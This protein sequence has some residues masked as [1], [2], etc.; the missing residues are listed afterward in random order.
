MTETSPETV[1]L[2]K[3][4][5]APAAEGGGQS[6]RRSLHPQGLLGGIAMFKHASHMWICGAM[7]AAA[8]GVVLVTGKAAALLP[9]AACVVMMGAMML[10]MGGHGGGSG[11]DG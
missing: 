2:S 5:S 1:H 6:S 10:M 3:R 8:L 11:K 4:A 7:V 9:A